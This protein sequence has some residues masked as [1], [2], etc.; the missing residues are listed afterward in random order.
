MN[1]F[2][3]RIFSRGV[4]LYE[5]VSLFIQI[6]GNLCFIRVDLFLSGNTNYLI[7]GRVIEKVSGKSFEDF[8]EERI[9]KPL[10]MAHSGFEPD[11]A[12]PEAV[13]GYSSFKREVFLRFDGDFGSQKSAI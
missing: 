11:P 2:I 6:T 9:L 12:G 4:S 7:L 13:Q 10:G 8:L 1:S 5:R 3:N